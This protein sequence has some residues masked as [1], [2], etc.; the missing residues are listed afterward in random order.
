VFTAITVLLSTKSDERSERR[1]GGGGV[2]IGFNP[3]GG[4]G[5]NFWDPFYMQQ[6]RQR[7]DRSPEEMGFL[8]VSRSVTSQGSL[9]AP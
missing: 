9:S 8:E 7:M 2:R 6:R 3:F 5:F 1:G 4:Y